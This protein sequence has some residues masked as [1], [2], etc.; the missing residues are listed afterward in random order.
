MTVVSK[1][2]NAVAGYPLEHSLSPLLHNY[3]YDHLGVDAE[4]RAF[5]IRECAE[6]AAVLRTQPIPLCAVTIPHKVTMMKFLDTID[7]PASAVGA[8]NTVIN[9]DG[10]L[11]GYNTDIAGV[12]YALRTTPLKRCRAF[13]LGAGGAARAA[14]YV[15]AQEG[16]EVFYYART[17]EHAHELARD[18]GGS[19]VS[20]EQAHAVSY[21]LICNTTPVGMH[22]TIR[23]SPLPDY[24]FRAGQAVFDIV[25]NPLETQ[26]L[27]DAKQAGAQIISGV[28]MF[29]AQACEQIRLWSGMQPDIE[30]GIA[31]IRN[32]LA[33][34]L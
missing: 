21:D 18:F 29:V 5:P 1:K 19:V 20:Y 24:H 16:A 2:I 27:Q 4:L 12:R 26:I 17:L 13:I 23:E 10:Q 6:I 30:E 28:E 22:P 33:R 14:A 9:R 32:E 11:C 34:N 7:A 31:L 15:L 3:Y 25:Y 8:V